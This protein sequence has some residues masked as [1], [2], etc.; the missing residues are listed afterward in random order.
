MGG[1]E[2]ML[3]QILR[4]G[5]IPTEAMAELEE[6]LGIRISNPTEEGRGGGNF[7]AQ[8]NVVRNDAFGRYPNVEMRNA[9]RGPVGA[10]PSVRQGTPPDIGYASINPTGR[11]ENFNAMEYVYGGPLVA[12][13]SCY[14]NLSTP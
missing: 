9:D 13:G 6:T 3:G 4:A 5:D 2:A 8:D 12:S 10:V 14:Y 1:L 7:R 11:F